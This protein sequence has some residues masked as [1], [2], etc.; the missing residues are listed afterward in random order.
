MLFSVYDLSLAT[1]ESID[2]QTVKPVAAETIRQVGGWG[3][4]WAGVQIGTSTG[5]LFGIETGPG[6]VLTA[7]AGGLIFG[8]AGYLGANWIADYIHNPDEKEQVGE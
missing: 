6:A 2:Q 7:A 1:K 8:V 4:S 3:S 5:A